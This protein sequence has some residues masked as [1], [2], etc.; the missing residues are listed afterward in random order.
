[1]NLNSESIIGDRAKYKI[2]LI[3]TLQSKVRLRA[4]LYLFI[5]QKI[6]LT[7]LSQILKKTKN[8]T[9]Y[10]MKQLINLGFVTQKEEKQAH[11]IKPITIYELNPF[12]TESVFKP[13]EDPSDLTPE[14]ILVFSRNFFTYNVIFLETIREFLAEL[15]N[16]YVFHE[17]QINDSRSAIEFHKIH[18]SPR[19]LIPLSENGFHKYIEKFEKFKLDFINLWEEETKSN[20]DLIHPYLMF[21]I[22]FPIK[23]LVEKKGK[24]EI[25]N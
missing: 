12:F 6:H 17:K 10:H 2:S 24:K 7:N 19:E 20:K 3:K 18:T 13:F 5:Y 15:G 25:S 8:T 23:E 1:M 22:I 9:I 21:Q 11:S 4:L 14:E 16:Y